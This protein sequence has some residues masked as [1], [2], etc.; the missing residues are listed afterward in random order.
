MA[1]LTL[2]TVGIVVYGLVS[3]RYERA[4]ALAGVTPAGA[5][6]VVGGNA[7][8]TFYAVSVGA[9][10]L[11]AVTFVT[12]RGRAEEI[13]LRTIPGL[14]LLLS[15]AAWSIL[16]TLLAPLMFPGL[17]TVTPQNALLLAGEVTSSNIAQIIYLLLGICVV[18]LLAR[19]DG[20]TPGLVS[21]PIVGVVVLSLWRY[22][23]VTF[24]VPFPD[25][26]FDNSPSLHYIELAPGGVPRFRGILSEP[27]SLAGVT[28]V[29]SVYG[30]WAAATSRGAK[31]V[32]WLALTAVSLYLG[33]VSTS[34]T[35][36]VAIPVLAMI[37]LL[38]SGIAFATGGRRMPVPVA[39]GALGLAAA[40]CWLV[41][42]IADY[43]GA[44]FGSKVGSAS[45]DERT[46]AD[47]DSFQIF[48]DTAG[49]GVGLGAGRASSFVPTLLSTT[50][51]IG[52]V[53]FVAAVGIIVTAALPLRGYRGVVWVV[54]AL[55]LTK[56][57][58]GPDLSDPTG[59]F[60]LSLGVLARGVLRSRAEA[61]AA[62]GAPPRGAEGRSLDSPS[63]LTRQAV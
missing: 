12:R 5:A 24:G 13:P 48:L 44:S 7:V 27:S 51:I 11:L 14:V 26:L 58:A 19:T 61:A 59:V 34:T 22:L 33:F 29:A 45:Y 25:V 62:L 8:P 37:A 20:A 15:F 28:I 55:L 40:A 53:L 35:F 47:A 38:T 17:K 39:L 23:W 30:L 21:I 9:F 6:V 2:T 10:A 63:R 57:I 32:W 50:G 41:P 49:F 60:W 3:R 42:V 52:T 56:A 46:G 18:V 43:L 31:R 4:L 1:V 16:V 36:I 54:V